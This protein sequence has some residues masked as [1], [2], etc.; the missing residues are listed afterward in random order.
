[1]NK[2]EKEKPVLKQIIEASTVGIQLVLSTFL[3]L[4]IG[5]GLDKL[6]GTSFLKFVFLFVGIIAGFR[7][8]F[9]IANK[10]EGKNS[11]SS[12][13]TDDTKDH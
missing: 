10:Q 4:A 13:A 8:L 9:R 11:G 12:D 7:E 5:Y 3:G 6:F 2:E 1:L